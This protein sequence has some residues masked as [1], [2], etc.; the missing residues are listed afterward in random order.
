[1]H[2]VGILFDKNN[3][4]IFKGDYYNNKKYG[5]GKFYL[6]EKEYYEG[7]FFDDKMEG[8]GIYHYNNGD[9][10][11]GYFKNNYKNGVGIMSCFEN[12]EIYLYEF[13]NDNY[14]GGIPLNPEEIKKVKNL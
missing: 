2:G 14:M 3:K 4:L 1:M 8:K 12:G 5:K 13:E 7:E 10:W 9:T 11:E 6:K